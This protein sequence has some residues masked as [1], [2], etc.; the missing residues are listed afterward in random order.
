MRS[1]KLLVLPVL[2]IVLFACQPEDAAAPKQS[3]ASV[4]KHLKISSTDVATASTLFKNMITTT[5]YKNYE[6]ARNVLVS[7]MNKNIV[8]FYT[9]ADYMNWISA[10]LSKTKFASVSSFEA[11]FDDMVAKQSILRANN[12]KLY[13]LLDEADDKQLLII[14]QP[15][16]A[17]PP[18]VNQTNPCQ[19]G[20]INTM[21]GTLDAI[22]LGT[23]FAYAFYGGDP[24]SDA[25][26]DWMYWT[27][28]E[29]CIDHFNICMSGC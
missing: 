15:V 8:Q 20:C 27:M 13:G 10:N 11:M 22:E 7:N 1:I 3:P 18:V 26:I 25:A 9:K 16:F 21:N 6:A 5:D 2:A 14:M 24:I 17:I 28:F 12:V 19:D 29:V 23:A 4:S